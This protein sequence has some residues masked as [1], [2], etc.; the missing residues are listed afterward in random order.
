[1]N[2]PVSPGH[3]TVRAAPRINRALGIIAAGTVLALLY[4]A[5]DVLVP[6]TLAFI[7]SLLIN[8]L[9]RLLRR[10]GLGQACSALAALVLLVLACARFA[11][12][13][14]TQV[15]RMAVSLPQYQ[16]TIQAKL[17][18]LDRLT[19]GGLQK[20]AVQAGRVI[21]QHVPKDEPVV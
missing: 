6:I 18:T 5:R 7:L 9:V 2:T 14:G 19:V 13:L 11:L 1:M 17:E 10:L 8:P 12:V 16:E 3:D 4:F 21:E 15:I 20:L